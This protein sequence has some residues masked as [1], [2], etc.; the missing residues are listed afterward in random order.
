M[1]SQEGEPQHKRVR[2]LSYDNYFF[3]QDIDNDGFEEFED[4]P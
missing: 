3:D 1:S 4:N 2:E